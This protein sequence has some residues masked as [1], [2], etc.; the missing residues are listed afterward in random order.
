MAGQQR[1]LLPMPGI[2]QL[3]PTASL[4]MIVTLHLLVLLLVAV[5]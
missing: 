1:W 2:L 4:A 5:L 3:F